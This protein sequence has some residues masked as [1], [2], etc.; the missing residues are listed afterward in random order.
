[1]SGTA[2]G[3]MRGVSERAVGAAAARRDWGRDRGR[4]CVDASNQAQDGDELKCITM[5]R[6]KYARARDERDVADECAATMVH[7]FFCTVCIG[8]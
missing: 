3:A 2:N 8:E 4:W 7:D 1:M 6:D 5:A